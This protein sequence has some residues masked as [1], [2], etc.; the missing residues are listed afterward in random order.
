MPWPEVITVDLRLQFVQ[1][2][3]RRR[4]PLVELCTAYGIS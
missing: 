2:A 3:L 1:D 4:V